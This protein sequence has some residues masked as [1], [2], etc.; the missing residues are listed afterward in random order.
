MNDWL[1]NPAKTD[2]EQRMIRLTRY[3]VREE[4][5]RLLLWGFIAVMVIIGLLRFTK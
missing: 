1:E 3:A 2:D 4:M 5:S